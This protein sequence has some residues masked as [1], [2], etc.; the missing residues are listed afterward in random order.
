[1][2]SLADIDRDLPIVYVMTVP[3]NIIILSVFFSGDFCSKNRK[4]KCILNSNAFGS[5][6]LLILTW[7]KIGVSMY[8]LTDFERNLLVKFA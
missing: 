7:L 5:H 2:L 3:F 8:I 6:V 4:K 1:M